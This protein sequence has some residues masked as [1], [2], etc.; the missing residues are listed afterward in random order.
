[1]HAKPKWNKI[2]YTE[3]RTKNILATQHHTELK[4]KTVYLTLC[5]RISFF[6]LV[7]MH[8][9]TG[10]CI[11]SFVTEIV[12]FSTTSESFYKC[13]G[14]YSRFKCLLGLKIYII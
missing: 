1:M 9:Q 14:K 5:F 11:R 2:E 7:I 6:P 12:M 3:K 4:K 13:E 10:E 8:F